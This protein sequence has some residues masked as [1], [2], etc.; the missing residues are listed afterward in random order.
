M[1]ETLGGRSSET[2]G[3]QF[4]ALAHSTPIHSPGTPLSL[5]LW[6]SEEPEA[7]REKCC[8]HLVETSC[9]DNRTTCAYWHFY[10]ECPCSVAQ[11][12][13]TLCDPKDCST[14]GF[15]V[16]H[17]LPELSQT[18][19]HCVSDAIQPSHPLVLLLLP[20]IFCSIRDFSNESVLC[21]RWPEIW[22]FS[23][24]ISPFNEYSGL[25]SFTMDWLDIFAV[26]G[27]LK[28]LLQ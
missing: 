7:G 11:S 1:C 16:L 19:V 8:R 20:L 6:L 2:Q 26:Q 5:K 21:I 23:F 3:C 4:F 14:P 10:F 13:P 24:I 27:T 12:C 28:G 25:I 17:H 22:S 18:H 15:P 9:N